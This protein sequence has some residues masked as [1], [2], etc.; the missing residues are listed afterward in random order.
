M[1][2]PVCIIDADAGFRADAA[3]HL[4]AHGLAT[5]TYAQAHRFLAAL[6][7]RR[8][9]CVILDLNLPDLSGL[10]LQ[11]RL[12]TGFCCMPLIF[13]AEGATTATVVQAMRE[14]AFDFLPKPVAM[15]DLLEAAQLAL[16]NQRHLDE[17]QVRRE[18]MRRRVSALTERER[19]VLMLALS[20]K[21]NKEISLLLGLSHRT[22]E[23][24][25]AHIMDKLDV[26][27]LLEIAH[28]FADLDSLLA[29][30]APQS[31]APAPVHHA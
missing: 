18:A 4:A 12:H 6:P 10:E 14:G 30:D 17:G 19:D 31:E 16:E 28:A 8:P 13:L 20:G 22:V 9:G 3:A 21:S 29:P 11:R 23:N 7:G 27:N 15:A 5:E 2:A 26:G 25:R 1:N 24:H